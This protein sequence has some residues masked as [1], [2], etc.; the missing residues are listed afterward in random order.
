MFRTKL[1]AAVAAVFTLMAIFVAVPNLAHAQEEEPTISPWTEGSLER[2]YAGQ[3]ADLTKTQADI[4]FGFAVVTIAEDLISD[5]EALGQDPSPL[6]EALDAYIAGLNEAQAELDEAA[7]IIEGNE[8]FDDEGNLID[9]EAA[10]DTMDDARFR[11]TGATLEYAQANLDFNEAIL[12]YLES[13][14]EDE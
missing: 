7:A 10:R 1:F 4:D 3:Q 8:G 5:L 12:D 13:L 14:R 9:V 2:R 6:Q 11:L